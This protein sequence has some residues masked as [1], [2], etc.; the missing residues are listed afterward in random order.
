[1][2]VPKTEAVVGGY[3]AKC[4]NR[5]DKE[6]QLMRSQSSVF[7]NDDSKEGTGQGSNLSGELLWRHI[8]S[9]FGKGH[10]HT[11]PAGF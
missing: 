9:Q 3:A 4:L 5:E 7:A 6:F 10:L 11:E 1:M 2:A 8:G